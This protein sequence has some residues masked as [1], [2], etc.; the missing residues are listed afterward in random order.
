M[1]LLEDSLQAALRSPVPNA[2]V[3]RMPC[4]GFQGV[5]MPVHFD[6]LMLATFR[7]IE[8]RLAQIYDRRHD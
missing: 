5:T 1:H 7:P 8:A 2:G 4:P 3:E 6:P